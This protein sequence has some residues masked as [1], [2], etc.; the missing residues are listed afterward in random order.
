MKVLPPPWTEAKPSKDTPQSRL[1][2]PPTKASESTVSCRHSILHVDEKESSRILCQRSPFPPE[3]GATGYGDAGIRS[4]AGALAPEDQT[5]FAFPAQRR[6]IF[7]V[8]RSKQTSPWPRNSHTSSTK[9][10]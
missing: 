1:K 6:V 9:P 7:S 2:H 4:C 5:H 8:S 10:F 3:S